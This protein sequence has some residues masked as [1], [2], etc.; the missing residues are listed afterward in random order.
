MKTYPK[1]IRMGLIDLKYQLW[2]SERH[3]YPYWLSNLHGD[4]IAEF[5][6]ILEVD[7]Y[8]KGLKDV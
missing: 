1:T 7:D 3:D 6:N 2:Y 5:K 8:M 4:K